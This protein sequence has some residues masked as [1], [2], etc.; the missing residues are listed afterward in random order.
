MIA[1]IREFP[2]SPGAITRKM[3]FMPS[4]YSDRAYIFLQVNVSRDIRGAEDFE[5]EYRPKRRK[6]LEI[7]C[8]AAKNEHPNL[9]TIIGIVID[10]PK[11]SKQAAED[12]ILMDCNDW[13]PERERH[14]Q[15][16]NE[17]FRFFKTKTLTREERVT[18]EFPN[19]ARKAD[20]KVR[21][22]SK[23]VNPNRNGLCSCGSGK[24]HR[25]CHGRR[26]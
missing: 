8:G 9:R 12:F 3:S 18:R 13:P 21:Q 26:T 2:E 7:A 16:A 22:R 15:E 20:R 25:K 19:V 4:F 11:F 23:A 6:M 24:L 5:T 17:P 14:Y 10:A 1:A